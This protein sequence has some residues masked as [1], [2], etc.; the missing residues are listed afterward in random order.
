M[1]IRFLFSYC[2]TA[3]NN[4][5]QLK[6]SPYIYISAIQKRYFYWCI[7]FKYIINFVKTENN[8]IF[9]YF[10]ITKLYDFTFIKNSVQN[11]YSFTQVYRCVQSS[12]IK[13][14]YVIPAKLSIYN[15][16]PL[17]M[18]RK[19][20]AFFIYAFLGRLLFDVFAVRLTAEQDSEPILHIFHIF[21]IPQLKISQNFAVKYAFLY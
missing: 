21:L 1:F 16:S 6:L 10:V 9:I 15:S 17:I 4:H 7:Q 2:N 13:L 11:R 3:K 14:P 18:M 20:L 5:R 8:N 12:Y 19:M